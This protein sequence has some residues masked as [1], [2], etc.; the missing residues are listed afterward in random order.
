MSQALNPTMFKAI[1]CVMNNSKVLPLNV[2]LYSRHDIESI[3]YGNT[4]NRLLDE[5][6]NELLNFP[7]RYFQI[8]P[9]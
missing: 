2:G 7:S 3:I 8:K 5:L 1:K 6:K 9:E 4:K